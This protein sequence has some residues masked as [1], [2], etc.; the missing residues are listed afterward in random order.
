MNK[1]DIR[2]IDYD[3]IRKNILSRQVRSRLENKIFDTALKIKIAVKEIEMINTLVS[4]NIKKYLLTLNNSNKMS[5]YEIDRLCSSTDKTVG[6]IRRIV[7]KMPNI[8]DKTY[9]SCNHKYCKNVI[10]LRYL[11]DEHHLISKTRLDAMSRLTTNY[12]DSNDI[13]HKENRF[14]SNMEEDNKSEYTDIRQREYIKKRKIIE[15]NALLKR[16][17][18]LYKKRYD[19]RDMLDKRIRDTR[20]KIEGTNV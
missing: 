10:R 2:Y 14:D 12:Y 8:I 15:K 20:L 11:N 6:Y 3:S 7:L 18:D 13:N 16:V 4:S 17:K 9:K 19:I 5:Y 1:L